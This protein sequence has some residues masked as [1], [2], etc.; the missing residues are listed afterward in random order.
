MLLEFATFISKEVGSRFLPCRLI[1]FQFCITRHDM[2]Y[3]SVSLR[4]SGLSVGSS[5][6][7]YKCESYRWVL[8][9]PRTI[10]FFVKRPGTLAASFRSVVLGVCMTVAAYLVRDGVSGKAKVGACRRLLFAVREG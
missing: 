6:R 8:S 9:I 5:L 10:L 3:F 1:S 2:V 7:H 4:A